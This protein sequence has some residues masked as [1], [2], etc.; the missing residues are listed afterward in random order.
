M[1]AFGLSSNGK[2]AQGSLNEIPRW[3]MDRMKREFGLSD[4]MTTDGAGLTDT[5]TQ[6]LKN[7]LS[8][9]PSTGEAFASPDAIKAYGDQAMPGVDAANKDRLDRLG[10]VQQTLN[11]VPSRGYVTGALDT[12]TENLNKA[13]FNLTDLIKGELGRKF[14]DLQGLSDTAY[15]DTGKNIFDT[16]SREVG[17][18]YNDYGNIRDTARSGFDEATK[19]LSKLGPGGDLSAA[20]AS[21]SFAPM[22][23]AAY[24]RLRASGVDPNSSEASGILQAVDT[25]RGRSMDDVLSKAMSDQVAQRNALTLGRTSTDA[26]YQEKQAGLA[27]DLQLEQAGLQRGNTANQLKSNSDI[28]SGRGDSAI[29]NESDFYTR[30]AN[31]TDRRNANVTADRNMGVQDV[32]LQ[33]GMADDFNAAALQ[34]I[35][36]NKDKFATGQTGLGL[37]IARQDQA[38][39]GIGQTGQQT[40]NR[41]VTYDQ[42]AQQF[43]NQASNGFQNAYQ[44][45]QAS[46]GW[47]GKLLA[48][49]G[50]GLL[51]NV[52][53]GLTGL[54]QKGLGTLFGGGGGQGTYNP[55]GA[56]WRQFGTY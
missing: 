6:Y 16:Y 41:A 49:M 45:E 38:G 3:L 48:G 26:G 35:N 55:A 24:R 44:T 34:N 50:S 40:S 5:Y 47:L 56:D 52:T 39:Q 53:G 18:V 8:K 19:E 4:Q 14:G 31:I 20:A 32:G 27:R 7:I 17:N 43:A 36:L 15:K 10:G 30:N 29:K 11:N 51:N 21:R 9:D 1:S 22:M 37:G 25:A 23:A 42:L 54:A 33:S 46:S 28:V 12:N 13:N 2:N